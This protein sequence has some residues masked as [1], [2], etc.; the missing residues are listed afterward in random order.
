MVLVAFIKGNWK[1]SGT[2]STFVDFIA[3]P[4]GGKDIVLRVAFPRGHYSNEV[5]GGVRVL[6]KPAGLGAR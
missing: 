2:I 5:P 4:L 1:T 6:A 3:D